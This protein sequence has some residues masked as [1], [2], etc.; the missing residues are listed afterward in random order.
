MEN[1]NGFSNFEDF[2]NQ[3]LTYLIKDRGCT[4]TY[5]GRFK[6]ALR[7]I[8]FFLDQ[9]N[10][11]MYNPSQDRDIENFYFQER[12]SRVLK[13]YEQ[14]LQR[15]LRQTSEFFLTRQ[16]V[17]IQT[18]QQYKYEFSGEIGS[19][20]ME[21]IKFKRTTL[22]NRS[23]HINV[24]IKKLHNF[25]EYCNANGIG[26]IHCVDYNFLITYI[27]QLQSY[28]L[29]HVEM[30]VSVLKIFFNY[31]F[32]NKLI[33]VDI[34]IKIPSFKRV[35]QPQLPS[36]YTLEE[37]E[38]LLKS[39]DRVTKIGK[40]NYAVLLIAIRLGFRAADISNLK[41]EN[42]DWGKSLI[43]INVMKTGQ[44]L[45]CPMFPDVG[46]AII[47]YLKH[48]RPNVTSPFI[49][50]TGKSPFRE[51]P[52]SNVVTHITQRAFKNSGIDVAN[53]KFGPHSLRHSLTSRLL[54]KQITLPI[55]S[56]VL[57]HKSSESTM[58]YMRIDMKSLT[59]CCLDVPT[60]DNNFYTQKGGV[61]YD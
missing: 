47:D 53:R 29:R 40:R 60:T 14:L 28:Q 11:I 32:E 59:Y 1:Y 17:G 54:E 41:F 38:K 10:Q 57:A 2:T 19:I 8:V 61:F 31:L 24:Y 18:H 13:D 12:P 9:N 37:I 7:K 4:E 3:L 48:G 22:L 42:I 50:L 39:I 46:N 35:S 5:A 43:K 27:S 58:Y 26:K 6:Y 51:F 25:Y 49:F 23:R 30:S 55:I 36:T 16:I 52:S 33:S 44:E 45:I 34:A 21:F 15:C 56:S 20:I